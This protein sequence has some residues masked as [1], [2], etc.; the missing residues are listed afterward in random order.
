MHNPS[1]KDI[2]KMSQE[3]LI[4]DLKLQAEDILNQNYPTTAGGSLVAIPAGENICSYVVVDEEHRGSIIKF[5]N[6]HIK[7]DETDEDVQI[8][9]DVVTFLKTSDMPLDEFEQYCMGLLVKILVEYVKNTEEAA[10]EVE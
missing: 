7:G 8:V 3:E 6:V 10:D 9:A 1:E 4:E 2:S 5:E